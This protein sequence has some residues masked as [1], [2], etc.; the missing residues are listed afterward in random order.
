MVMERHRQ[1]QPLIFEKV[2]FMFFLC[3]WTCSIEWVWVRGSVRLCDSVISLG[4][5]EL[6][7]LR[8]NCSQEIES[9]GMGFAPI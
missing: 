9:V 3:R 8:L 2:A 6:Y 5:N 1:P 7:K 4:K